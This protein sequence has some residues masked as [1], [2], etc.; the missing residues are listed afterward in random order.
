MACYCGV[1]SFRSQSGT[2]INRKA[3]VSNLSNRQI[4]SLLSMAARSASRS[5]PVFAEYFNRTLSRGKPV[6]LVYN[7]L[8]NKIITVVYKLIERD[9]DFDVDYM[10]MHSTG[11]RANEPAIREAV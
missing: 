1:A 6:A 11:Q 3:S 7:N 9:C 8:R 5:N 2:S 4:K 10:R